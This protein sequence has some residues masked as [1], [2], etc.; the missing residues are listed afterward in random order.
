[1]QHPLDPNKKQLR[2][3]IYN[4]VTSTYGTGINAVIPGH[5]IESLK[6]ASVYNLDKSGCLDTKCRIKKEMTLF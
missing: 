4:E 2:T 3:V 5:D 1:M 6:I